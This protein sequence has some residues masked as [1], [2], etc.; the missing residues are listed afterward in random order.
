MSNQVI[1]ESNIDIRSVVR[2]RY[3]SIA[4]KAQ[5][6]AK[7]D[8]CPPSS[9]E[10]CCGTPD[11][12]SGMHSNQLS[13][14]SKLYEDPNVTEL[15][16][17]VTDI[18]LGCGDP[19]TLAAL[20][21]GQTVL[22]LGSGGGIDCF[23]AGKKVGPTGQVIGVDMTASMIEMARANKEKIGAEN[24]DFRLG[25]IEHL[26][27]SDGSVDVII[28][29]CVIN[30]SPDKPQVFREAYRVMK[31]GGKL[32]VSDIV[33]DGPLPLEIK[34]NLSA[35]AGCIAGALDV[36]DYIRAIEEA[37]FVNVEITPSYWDQEVINSAVQQLEPEMA[38]KVEKA[39]SEGKVVLVVSEGGD[40]EIIEIDN[41]EH[42]KDFDP[43]KAIY[44]A[45]IIAYKPV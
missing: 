11:E 29:N 34:S 26:P 13:M 30:L 16:P 17:E 39:K 21:P 22:D 9:Q 19:V 31:P 45:K 40:G 2:E 32:A 36:R 15:P 23:L 14:V 1:S 24:V 8:C 12:T 6:G 28:S 41:T 27:V 3:G 25:E 18:S 10:S 42:F 37:G 43:Q 5:A 20:Q 7:T 44:S 33:T 35:W 4:E 38:T